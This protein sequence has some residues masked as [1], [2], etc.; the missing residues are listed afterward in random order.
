[1]DGCINSGAR[2]F[3]LPKASSFAP[4]GLRLGDQNISIE[5]SVALCFY[6]R[7]CRSGARFSGSHKDK[8]FGRPRDVPVEHNL[9]MLCSSK[10]Y[11]FQFVVSISA[12]VPSFFITCS[13]SCFVTS[14]NVQDAKKVVSP[15]ALCSVTYGH[16][17][18]GAAFTLQLPC[19]SLW[20]VGACKM[21]LLYP[22]TSAL[23][24]IFLTS[25]FHCIVIFRYVKLFALVCLC[26]FLLKQ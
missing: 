22:H 13:I 3:L 15:A 18:H 8:L 5:V 1:M 16:K 19:Y 17:Y 20:S 25:L 4:L 9:M 7:R 10:G 6:Y 11:Y 14:L 24:L 21:Q 23:S 26:C 2:Y 12:P